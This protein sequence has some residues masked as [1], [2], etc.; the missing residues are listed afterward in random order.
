MG[1]TDNFDV[2]DATDFTLSDQIPIKD[3]STSRG[4]Y[5]TGQYLLSGLAGV[6]SVSA[7]AT[8]LTV[9]QASHAGRTVVLNNTV[10]I[11]V[12][13][14]AATGTG[15]KYAIVLKT[16]ATAT[17]STIKV[18]NTVDVMQGLIVSLNTTA[19]ALIGFT[20]TATS[21]TMT[22][23]GGTTGGGAASI[24]TI[25]DIAAGFFQVD[26][27]DTAAMTTTPYSASV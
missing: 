27:R 18:A 13:L 8:V 25:T 2:P 17:Q 22:F 21:D 16:A 12:T 26:G 24:Y 23:N 15:A 1:T 14:P 20:N 6:V 7:G 3:A 9:T 5:I 11:A 4:G 10:P 19:G